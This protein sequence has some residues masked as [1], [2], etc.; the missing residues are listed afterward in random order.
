M[1]NEEILGKNAY[2]EFQTRIQT[3]RNT[4]DGW[5]KW[6]EEQL[7]DPNNP[8]PG[9]LLEGEE[10]LVLTKQKE[11]R[12]K[13]G[14]GVKRYTQLPFTDENLR[15]LISEQDINMKDG[16]GENSLV[17]NDIDNNQAI[18]AYSTALG[19]G[20]TAGSKGFRIIASSGTAGKE[21][22]YTLEGYTGD[23][24]VGDEYSLRIT[25][26]YDRQ[27]KITAIDDTNGVITVDN[28]AAETLAELGEGETD[29]GDKNT[30]RVESKP[31]IGNI[32]I[33]KSSVAFGIDSKALGFMSF[34]EGSSTIAY[35]KYAHAEG[36][37]TEAG[38]SAHSEGR[39]THATGHHSH[40]EGYSTTASKDGAHAEGKNTVA[41]GSISHAEGNSTTAS[42]DRAHAEGE[43]T[44]ASGSKSHAEG[45]RSNKNNDTLGATGVIAH[46]EGY[47]TTAS[48]EA[49]HSE[50]RATI[51]SG[52]NSHA[53]GQDSKASNQAS[54]AEG[55]TTLSGN[56][57]SHSEG[58]FTYAGGEGA[59]A[60]GV[61]ASE[62]DGSVNTTYGAKNK[63]AHVEGIK[64]IALGQ[65]AH[66]EGNE[67]KAGGDASHVE[68]YQPGKVSG[69]ETNYGA[70][71]TGAHAEGVT[72]YADGQGAHA[73]GYSTKAIAKASHSEGRGTTASGENSHAR[74]T[75]TIASGL[76]AS[77]EGSGTL[78][79][80]EATHAEGYRDLE[81]ITVS[82]TEYT[83]GAVGKGAH[84]EGANTST[85]GE[86]AHAEGKWTV[87]NG[88]AAHAEGQ[89]TIASNTYAHAE[90]F[91]TKSTGEA[92]HAEG[93]GTNAT[94]KGAHTEGINTKASGQAAH[95]EGFQNN[96]TATASHAEGEGTIA[97]RSRQHVQGKY[98]DI[99][100]DSTKPD[101]GDYAHI[102]GGGEKDTNRW[103]IHTLDWN[104]KAWYKDSVYVGGSSATNGSKKLITADEATVAAETV[105][106]NKKLITA[107][108]ATKAAE[109]VVKNKKLITAD[110][111]KAEAEKVIDDLPKVATS[112]SY[113]DL[114][115]K[116]TSMMNPFG[117]ELYCNDELVDT[118]KGDETCIIQL[119]GEGL[120]TDGL[121]TITFNPSSSGSNE[122]ALKAVYLDAPKA[123]VHASEVENALGL[124]VGTK[125]TEGA[126]AQVEFKR[127]LAAGRSGYLCKQINDYGVV[128]GHHVYSS[129]LTYDDNPGV[130]ITDTKKVGVWLYWRGSGNPT[131]RIEF[132][133]D[134]TQPWDVG[135]NLPRINFKIQLQHGWN[136][137]KLDFAHWAE[138]TENPPLDGYIG[139]NHNSDRSGFVFYRLR[140]YGTATDE[141]DATKLQ[142]QLAVGQIAPLVDTLTI[143]NTA[144]TEEQLKRLL[145]LLDYTEY[146]GGTV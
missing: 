48:G 66:A 65:A 97:T 61:G 143:G 46:S 29:L 127:N 90:G 69:T 109:D 116:P 70:Y 103:N 89:T 79:S 37:T 54:H 21:G 126:S 87:A 88:T 45:Y 9:V 132:T 47:D 58:K 121:G 60:E 44:L 77:A 83:T 96:A 111:A 43:N 133:S 139:W 32:D 102:V 86:G 129:L 68:G 107:E 14:D 99:G 42:G 73:E 52:K 142:Y 63:A 23:Y 146:T 10:I 117:L 136:F 55:V 105:V 53:E 81:K 130:D 5:R 145:T 33:G 84:T 141:T 75:N 93:H 78:A 82:G 119:Q 56:S 95:A 57:G 11:L 113:N 27:G 140:I 39:F 134:R 34:T 144:I 6:E 18:S 51:A 92:S 15:A 101:A 19:N 80:G 31:L 104:G 4:D 115:D 85:N 17:G 114:S 62:T 125:D 135:S 94:N 12:R 91:N 25:N 118:Y 71:Q 28:Y 59:H 138:D 35:G 22:T 1:T 50:G 24:E 20:T 3:K 13:I 41:S 36:N 72:T 123:F 131:I 64:T 2:Q 128:L 74:G 7:N 137:Y 67:G 110:E 106:N 26:M 76:S 40:A 30:F 100:S 108:D 124:I 38:Y 16:T 122:E 49:S 98:N 8:A 120:T 112:G